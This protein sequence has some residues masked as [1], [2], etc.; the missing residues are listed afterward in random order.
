MD[1]LET[2]PELRAAD[3][4]LVTAPAMSAGHRRSHRKQQRPWR[5]GARSGRRRLRAVPADAVVLRRIL[6]NL[7][8]NAIDSLDGKLAKSP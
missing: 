4:A 6:E 7:V 5:L 8:G 3:T 1:Y 2:L